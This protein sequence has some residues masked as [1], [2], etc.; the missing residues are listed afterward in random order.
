MTTSFLDKLNGKLNGRRPGATVRPME[1]LLNKAAAGAPAAKKEEEVQ[2]TQSLS[3]DVYQGPNEIILYALAAGVDPEAFDLTLDE[4]NDVLTIR[5]SRKRTESEKQLAELK[6]G[7]GTFLQQEC[8]W[9]PFYRKI[10]LPAQ[11]DVV[12]TEA[13]FRKGVLMVTLPI[14]KSRDGRK[15]KVVEMLSAPKDAPKS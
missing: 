13:V 5:G 9:E 11:V 2:T 6:G 10:I 15:L 1:Q 14:L 4:E 8:S 3:V 12:K 7:D